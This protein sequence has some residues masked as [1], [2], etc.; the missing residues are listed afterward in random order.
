[1]TSDMLLSVLSN[2]EKTDSLCKIT[3]RSTA[4]LLDTLYSFYLNSDCDGTEHC[5]NIGSDHAEDKA[6]AAGCLE[7][8]AVD[9]NIEGRRNEPDSRAGHHGEEQSSEVPQTITFNTKDITLGRI[10][11]AYDSSFK[12]FFTKRC[13]RV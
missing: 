2:A 6:R 5:E 7:P 13:A 3:Q 4:C 8:T 11:L 1:M 10:M 12:G 9:S